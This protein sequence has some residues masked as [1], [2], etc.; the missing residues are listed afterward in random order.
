MSKKEE[1][2]HVHGNHS[3][4]HGPGCGHTKLNHS[5]HTDYLHDGHIHNLHEGHVDEH[6]LEVNSKNPDDCTPRHSC[7]GHEKGHIHGPSCGHEAIPHGD[8]VDY[9]VQGHLH[10]NHEGHC[11]DHGPVTTSH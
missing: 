9:L 10:R 3:H 11:D 2:H 7:E 1:G 5:G 6:K 8:H 4:Q